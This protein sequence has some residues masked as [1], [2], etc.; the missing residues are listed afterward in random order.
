[1]QG[2]L[3]NP[4]HTA[5]SFARGE[6]LRPSKLGPNEKP[7]QQPKLQNFFKDSAKISTQSLLPDSFMRQSENSLSK[8]FDIESDN[9]NYWP[10][11]LTNF[12]CM[13]LERDFANHLMN[14]EEILEIY[15]RVTFDIDFKER[16]AQVR[17]TR[18]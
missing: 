18:C 14:F 3:G 2:T 13:L 7:N 12:L 11:K 15:G 17:L 4:R 1:M 10:T 5:D 9:R 8:E 16:I 6:P